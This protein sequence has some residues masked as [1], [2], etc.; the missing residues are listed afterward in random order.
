[1]NIRRTATILVAIL[2]ATCTGSAEET[3]PSLSLS[4]AAKLAEDAIAAA[5]LPADCFVRS[6]TLMDNAYYQVKYKPSPASSEGA[7]T[8]KV[9]VIKVSMDGKVTFGHFFDSPSRQR[10]RVIR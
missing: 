7:T 9:D 4:K 8:R 3:A 5:S 1:M 2:Y 6:V 10:I